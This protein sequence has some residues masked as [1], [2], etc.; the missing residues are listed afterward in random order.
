MWG[1][2][3]GLR[4][5]ICGLFSAPVVSHPVCRSVGFWSAGIDVLQG[6]WFQGRLVTGLTARPNHVPGTACQRL[7]AEIWM[8]RTAV[9]GALS[10]GPTVLLCAKLAAQRMILNSHAPQ[11]EHYSNVLWTTKAQR[12]LELAIMEEQ[13]LPTSASDPMRVSDRRVR[14]CK[15][16]TCSSTIDTALMC[17]SQ[18]PRI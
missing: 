1:S 7:Q 11:N 4:R 13:I 18:Q 17:D 10:C 6:F 5:V 8:F 12:G 16:E 2:R 14:P 3:L 9:A 15:K